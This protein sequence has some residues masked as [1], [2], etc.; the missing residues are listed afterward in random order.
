MHCRVHTK[1]QRS[2][3]MHMHMQYDVRGQYLVLPP[4]YVFPHFFLDLNVIPPN[5]HPPVS[6]RKPSPTPL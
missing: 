2:G 5:L 6:L 1:T 4:L 3:F